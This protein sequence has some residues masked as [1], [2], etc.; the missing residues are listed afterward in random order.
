MS[1]EER[2]TAAPPPPCPSL[3]LS[4]IIDITCNLDPIAIGGIVRLFDIDLEF[5]IQCL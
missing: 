5:L 3:S 1:S 4:I 2:G